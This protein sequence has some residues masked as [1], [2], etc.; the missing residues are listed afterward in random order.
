M[1]RG[2]LENLTLIISSPLAGEDGGGGY[3]TLLTPTL[4]LPHQEGGDTVG[5][6]II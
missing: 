1:K 4:A 2:F 6:F 3:F 5:V